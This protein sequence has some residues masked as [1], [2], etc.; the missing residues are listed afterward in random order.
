MGSTEVR[1]LGPVEV[2]AKPVGSAKQRALLTLL[3]LSSEAVS[4][5][6]I[7]DRLWGD[8]PPAAANH[9]VQVYVSELRKLLPPAVSIEST[10]H[11][12]RLTGDDDLVDARRF[13]RVLREGAAAEALALWRGPIE[14]LPGDPLV[15]RLHELRLSAVEQHFEAALRSGAGSELVPELEATVGENP[16]REHLRAQLML[17]LYRA[18]RQ[19]DALESYQRARAELDELGLA[20][21]A[22]LRELERAILRREPHLD[23]D[24]EELRARRHLPAPATALIGRRADIDAVVAH[25]RGHARLV[26][27]TG[28]GGVGKTRVA[29]Q[30]AHELAAHFADGVFFAGLAALRD[31]AL[32]GAEVARALEVSGS[33]ADWLRDRSA[34]VLVDNFEQ[35]DA[36]APELASL[37]GAAPNLR[38][39][40]T[41]RRPLRVYGEV[42]HALATLD[43]GDAVALFSERAAAVQRGFTPTQSVHELCVRLDN[44]PLA[45]ELAAARLRDLS[46]SELVE[47]VPRLELAA[48]GP[49]D[50]D[51]RHQSLRNAIAWSHNL[52]PPGEQRAFVLL[53][54]FAGGF[55]HEDARNV[56]DVDRAT[57]SSLRE[58]SLVTQAAERLG[59]LETIREFAADQLGDDDDV[60]RRHAAYFRALAARSA[61][62]RRT[63]REPGWMEAMERE[64][65]NVRTAFDWWLAHDPEEAFA[66]ADDAY[67][68]WY[69]RGH[70]A[71]GRRAFRLALEAHATAPPTARATALMYTAAFAFSL[72]DLGEAE[73][74]A[75]ESLAVWRA[76]GDA[77]MTARGLVLLATIRAE[78]DAH[79]D[80]V[81]LVDEAVELAGRGGDDHL[82]AFTISHLARATLYAGDYVRAQETANEAI[83]LLRSVGDPDGERSAHEL[84]AFAALSLG[85]DDLAHTEF[86]A[87]LELS[88]RV[89]NPM[90]K[91]DNAAGLAAVATRKGDAVTAA[92]ILGAHDA[93][94]AERN[95]TSE[96]AAQRVRALAEAAA[97]DALGDDGYVA[98]YREGTS[99]PLEDAAGKM[100]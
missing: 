43:V 56:C 50:A 2:G 80:A 19:A 40:V 98:A 78:C 23:V 15:G 76:E 82:R 65:E 36:A 64:R 95:L 29:L 96:A 13:E 75:E 54:V 46:L 89:G 34:L 87:A 62:V 12:Y 27:L 74:L 4:R 41:S 61:G 67:R 85:D 86:V 77:G 33:L 44:L 16:L 63:E 48:G 32:V 66:F 92:R 59:M 58:K 70:Y 99:L 68:F 25:L 39:L 18:G 14:E 10:P 49:R 94:V 84:V 6:A 88:E 1:V 7:V 30:A 42:E 11:G 21:S 38:L 81:R 22:E 9:A 57:I 35:V 24:P 91:A 3:A 47:T 60:H 5:D 26:S 100:T 45:I 53:S 93:Y 83:P 97:R 90:G 72:R 52:L 51:V 20:P 37:L 17:A 73:A 28:P 71:D 8:T 69:I 31:P 55:T 79:D